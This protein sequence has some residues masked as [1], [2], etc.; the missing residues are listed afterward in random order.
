MI[1]NNYDR[2]GRGYARGIGGVRLQLDLHYFEQT[3][4]SESLRRTSHAAVKIPHPLN[5]Y[6]FLRQ[7]RDAREFGHL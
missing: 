4:Q 7:R 5:G 6:E 1:G 3:L 2:P